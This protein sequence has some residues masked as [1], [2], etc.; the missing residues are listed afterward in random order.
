MKNILLTFLMLIPIISHTTI[1]S[2]FTKCSRRLY[3]VTTKTKKEQ[4]KLIAQLTQENIALKNE[5]WELHQKWELYQQIASQKL[6]ILPT[7]QSITPDNHHIL[8]TSH[9]Y[10]TYK[11]L[12]ELKNDPE[13]FKNTIYNLMSAPE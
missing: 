5:N 10:E 3:T 7:K 9:P 13:S 2:M 12:A 1:L 4:E 6:K 11:Y 8:K